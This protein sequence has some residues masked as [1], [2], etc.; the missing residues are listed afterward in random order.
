MKHIDRIYRIIAAGG[1]CLLAGM[2]RAQEVSGVVKSMEGEGLI[3]AN[4]RWMDSNVGATTDEEGRFSIAR[5]AGKE[6]LVVSYVGYESD[7]LRVSTSASGPLEIVLRET[8]M[9]EVTVVGRQ[10]GQIK[11][12][13]LMN[14]TSISSAELTRAACCNLGESFTTNPSVDVSY[15][16]AA[17]GARQIKLLGLSGSY[18]QMLTENIPNYRGA[19]APYALGYVPGPWMQS[20]QVS[21][22]SSSVKNG[23]ESITGQINVEFL[24]PQAMET[25]NVNL[26]GDNKSRLE[27]NADANLHLNGKLSTGLLLH[28]EDAWGEHDD[29]GDGFLDK[30]KVRQF[31]VQNRWAWIGDRYIFQAAVKALKEERRSGQG[32]HHMQEASSPDGEAPAERFT[33]RQ[34]TQRYEA[35]A[36]N[37]Y[38]FN[39]EH[40]TNLALILSGTLHKMDAAYGHKAY[41]VDQR[42]LYA[43][44]LFETDFTRMHNLSAGLSLNHDRYGEDYRMTHD[45]SAGL[46]HE[47]ERETTPGAYVQYTFNWNDKLVAM[48]GIRADRSSLYGTFVTP[49]AHVKY[50]PAEWFSLRASVGKGYRSVHPLAEYNYLMV[51]GRQLLIDRPEQEEA[52]NYGLSTT[53]YIPLAGKTLNLNAEYYY[54]DFRRQYI[55]DYESDPEEIRLTNLRGKSRS[56]TLQVDASYPLFQGMTLTAAWRLNDVKTTYAGRLMERLLTSRYKG[57]V[58]ASYQTPLAIWQFDLTLQLNGG[59]RMPSPYETAD[60]TPSW[61]HRFAAYE[62]LSAQITR[63]FRHWSV[64]IGGEN[65]TGFKQKN[66]IIGADHPWSTRFDPTMVYGP[67]HGAMFYAGVRFKLEKM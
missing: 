8:E 38:I 29:N 60:G 28:Y 43:S 36:K 40:N 57:L 7:T 64:Y 45:L 49:R 58:T 63:W 61:N 21:K 48:A 1:L 59:G 6:R 51:S 30:P 15:S 9:E 56:H 16:D 14:E 54:T 13:G 33:I 53:F 5:P 37:A 66:A 20:I 3:G 39:K 52:W 67:L 12:R 19:A 32:G 34:E 10:L 55:V 47:R 23:Y 42:N 18:V 44:L 31:N 62:Q 41:D 25:L 27:A 17:T 22:G 2:L 26:Y 50:A 4:I 11:S 65:L 35:F 46:R 24:K